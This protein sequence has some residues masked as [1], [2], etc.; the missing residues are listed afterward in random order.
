MKVSNVKEV[1]SFKLW[2]NPK[3]GM[4]IFYQDLILENGDKINIGK[5][6]IQKEGWEIR[7]EII[8]NEGE[9]E[10]TKAKAT[11]VTVNHNQK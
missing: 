6:K 1:K 8:G 3:T 9:Q 4:S 7:Y 10:F 2:T 5:S 11:K